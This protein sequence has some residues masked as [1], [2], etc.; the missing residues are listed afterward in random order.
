MLV[1]AGINLFIEVVEITFTHWSLLLNNF[2]DFL[3][4]GCVQFPLTTDVDVVPVAE[5]I[6]EEFGELVT[7]VLLIGLAAGCLGLRVHFIIVGYFINK[8]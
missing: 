3:L 6:N 5:L 2:S 8:N 4:D 1:N 7:G